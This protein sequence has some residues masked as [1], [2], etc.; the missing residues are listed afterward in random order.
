MRYS[1][2]MKMDRS[3]QRSCSTI[4]GAWS[5]AGALLLA[6]CS[7]SEALRSEVASPPGAAPKPGVE[8]RREGQECGGYP[9]PGEALTECAAGLVCDYEG[10]A[11]DAPG[12]CKRAR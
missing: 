7:R 2:R 10:A 6:A 12:R 5:A 4:R 8:I 9:A 11:V 3:A 1:R